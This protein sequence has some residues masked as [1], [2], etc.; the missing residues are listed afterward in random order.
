MTNPTPHLDTNELARNIIGAAINVHRFV[1]MGLHEKT[2][3]ACLLHELEE[4]GLQYEENVSI[5][6]FYKNRFIESGLTLGL[7]VEGRILVDVQA[8]DFIS[9]ERMMNVLN[10]LRH[11]DLSLGLILNFETKYLKGDAIRRVVNG[12]IA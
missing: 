5:P 1:G 2:Y 10:H 8:V 11:A 4:M 6:L 7:L 3:R 9:E 12:V